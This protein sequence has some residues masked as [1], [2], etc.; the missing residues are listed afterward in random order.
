M[1]NFKLLILNFKLT[2]MNKQLIIAALFSLTLAACSDND[3]VNPTPDT[4][5]L[6]DS[7][8]DQ[9]GEDVTTPVSGFAFATS[10][11]DGD[12]TANL[13]LTSSS[14]TEG[15]LSPVGNG[16]VNDGATEWAF[17]ADRYL[18]ALTYN[19]GNAGTTRSY[20]MADDGELSARSAEY[21]ISRFT[22]F[23]KFGPY[24]LTSSTG[25]APSSYADEAGNL[26]KMFLLTYLDVE[27][28]TAVASPS[29]DDFL[30]ENFLGNG[31]YATLSGFQE[32]GGKLYSG[33]VGM[34]L[35]P[36]GSAVGNGQ[37]I[38]PGNEDLVKQE[39]GGSGSGAYTKGELQG[40]QY[41]D[42]CWVAVF[43]NERLEGKKLLRTD[44][45]SYPCG[46]YRSQYYQTIWA[47][48]NGDLYVFSPSYAKSLADARQQTKLDAG[49]VRI[50]AG[51]DDFDPDYYYNLEAQTD[52]KSF[53]RCWH[54][55]G[56]YFLLR[57]YDRPFAAEGTAVANQ[58][59]VFNG[60]TGRLTYV[61]GLP[62]ASTITDFGKMPYVADGCIYM[63]VMSSDAY[64]ALY[65][66]DP[67]TATATRGITLQV[68]TVTAVGRLTHY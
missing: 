9:P 32:A 64:A 26:P 33:V 28:E 61:S 29:T 40:T 50:K 45:I 37:Y 48:D 44:K 5:E 24:L 68:N 43:D 51:A 54:A 42:E 57:M 10:V 6:P 13:L 56:N 27:A 63:P 21:K 30:S 58:L 2:K 4:P 39:S 31:E 16:L 3:P 41:P 14:L 59:A 52:G 60:D 53:L 25:N 34:G 12:K 36:Y 11:Q 65:R 8:G 19:Q 66:I 55:G 20:V 35:S 23:G 15:S 49:V 67:A 22:T 38:L 17:Y 62:E 1:K 46:R 18:Y 7:G 47:A